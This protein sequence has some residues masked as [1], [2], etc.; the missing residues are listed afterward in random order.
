MACNRTCKNYLLTGMYFVDPNP[1]PGKNA[2]RWIRHIAECH[3]YLS[4]R[5]RGA[6]KG[7]T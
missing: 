7:S 6:L 5:R 1:E 4:M 3:L 2:L